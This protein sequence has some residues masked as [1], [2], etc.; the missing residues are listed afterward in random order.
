MYTMVYLIT[1]ETNGAS[2]FTSFILL[3]ITDY[4]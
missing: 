3:Q 4:D 1:E 2:M